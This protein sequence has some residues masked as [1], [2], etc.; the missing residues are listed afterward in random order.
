MRIKSNYIRTCKLFFA[1]FFIIASYSYRA[2][3]QEARE[4]AVSIERRIN[5]PQNRAQNH[6]RSKGGDDTFRTIDGS[7]NNKDNPDVGASF[8]ELIR[9]V[10]SDYGDGISS[11]AGQDRPSPREV[12]NAVSSQNESIPN[13]LGASD[14]LWQWGQFLDHD[15]DLTDGTDP[16]EYADIGV[17]LGDLFFD[18]DGTGDQVIPFNRSIY[19]ESTG[20]GA[21]NPRQQ[22][23]E[24]SGWIDASNVYGSDE[25]RAITLRTNDGTGKLKTSEGNLLPFNTEGLPN[26]GGSSSELF[27]AGDVR[28]N[29]QVALTAMHTL[30][31]REHN[32]LAEVYAEQHPD[33]DGERIFQKARQIVG[34]E[35]QVITYKE[36]LP[37]LLGNRPLSRYRGYDRD[38]DGSIRNIFST[39]A[40]RFGHSAL[41]PIIL[42]LDSEG[43][44]IAEGN[45][46]LRDAFFSPSIIIDE[47]GIE[48]ILRGLAGQECQRIDPFIVDGVRN[49]LFGDPGS[50][51]FDLESLNIQ[52]GRD[53]GLPSYN[54]AREALG[55]GRVE[56]F[57][58]ISSDPDIQG[59]LAS[60]YDSVDDVDLWI[61]GLS[62][63]P[64][65]GS[66]LGELFSLILKEQFETLRDGDRFWYEETLSKD[67]IRKVERTK[68]SDIIRRNTNIGDEIQDDVFHVN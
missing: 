19:A 39:A 37:V 59:R 57:E 17:P 9:F 53:H 42:R 14:F 67:E 36:F 4:G 56:S 11:L 62:E 10:D 18:P 35:V 38:V 13:T 20:T 64:E 58:E 43:H 47:G 16:S 63:D 54:D 2:N 7:G 28:A 49:F 34:A 61:G 30:F 26:A 33:W 55:L 25:E 6:K 22:L 29:E 12:S 65:S 44:E 45:L 15:I 1:I 52:R 41:S 50:G 27:L 21:D 32:R 24:I 66:H 5:H 40:Y 48:P 51:G 46:A 8:T 60:V 31:V 68:L 3:S 23:N